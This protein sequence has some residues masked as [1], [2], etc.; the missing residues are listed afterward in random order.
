MRRRRA[1]GQVTFIY[2]PRMHASDK[3]GESDSGAP[4]RIGIIGAGGHG[5]LV[6]DILRRGAVEPVGS[7]TPTALAGT[8]VC[9]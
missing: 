2:P 3:L 7:S 6:L 8:Q 1:D 9:G 5:K 4:M